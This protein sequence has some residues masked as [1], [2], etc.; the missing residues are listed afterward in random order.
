MSVVGWD[1]V[2]LSAE[3]AEALSELAESALGGPVTD[4]GLLKGGANNKVLKIVA[5]EKQ[6][7]AKIYFK[8]EHDSRDRLGAEFGFL[9]FAKKAGISCVPKAIAK[10]DRSGIGIY[11]YVDGAPFG[12]DATEGDVEE[13]A[14]FFIEL[15]KTKEMSGGA[16][17]PDA[18]EAWFR[19]SD[20]ID[21]VERR[22]DVL[23]GIGIES[24]LEAE[25]VRFVRGEAKAAFERAREYAFG[26][27]KAAG[28]DLNCILEDES[29]CISPSDFGFHN[30]I[31]RAD[32][33]LVFHDFEYAGWD[34]P[35]KT[36]CDFFCQ[37][38]VPAPTGMRKKLTEDLRNALRLGDDFSVRAEALF[39][40]YRVKWVCIMLNVFLP[41]GRERR[42][43]AQ[44]EAAAPDIKTAQLE[45]ARRA[46]EYIDR[47]F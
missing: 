10:D 39:P 33:R 40:V 4:A 2:G 13:A 15:N 38:A 9:T 42:K 28:I 14:R 35:A 43:F 11:E 6:Y 22:L 36:V 19:I 27:V 3:T 5:E 20:H 25:V 44:T 46:I 47:S 12:T 37:P 45:K 17:L 8:H 16:A 23:S 24:D 7:T 18:S 41:A 32:G 21:C 29:R 30:V 26:K 31:R 34:D 1:G